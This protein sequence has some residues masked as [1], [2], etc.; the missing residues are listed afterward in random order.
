M[1][2]FTCFPT[3]PFLYRLKV[4]FSEKLRC[5]L[6]FA[7]LGQGRTFWM[8][9]YRWH[10]DLLIFEPFDVFVTVWSLR[11]LATCFSESC[12]SCLH[13]DQVAHC[14]M[15]LAAL[16]DHLAHLPRCDGRDSGTCKS[17]SQRWASYK[18]V[19]LAGHMNKENRSTYSTHT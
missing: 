16:D 7:K 5:T 17:N 13:L 10:F 11:L 1:F 6:V 3:C 4:V 14:G 2:F 18:T 19:V 15:A 8:E 9:V 12:V